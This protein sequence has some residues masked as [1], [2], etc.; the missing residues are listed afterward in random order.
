MMASLTLMLG[1]YLS[2]TR[3][4]VFLVFLIPIQ[5]VDQIPKTVRGHKKSVRFLI[6]SRASLG[7]ME[8][9]ANTLELNYIMDRDVNLLS[10]GEL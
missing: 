8:E 2:E 4:L 3:L 9:I 1:G 6:E 10:G 5:Y 7:N